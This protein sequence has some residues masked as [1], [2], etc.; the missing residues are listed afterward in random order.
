MADMSRNSNSASAGTLQDQQT[1]PTGSR[2]SRIQLCDP[3]PWHDALEREALRADD[4]YITEQFVPEELL[5]RIRVA[6]RRR[7]G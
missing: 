3:E 4:D 6:L 5:T 2:F 1:F 7:R